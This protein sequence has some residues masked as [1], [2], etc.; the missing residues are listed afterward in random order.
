MRTRD[1]NHFETQ[2]YKQMTCAVK[3]NLQRIE[4]QSVTHALANDLPAVKMIGN[5]TSVWQSYTTVSS[6]GL[7]PFVY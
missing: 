4:T 1:K 2:S 6:T 3:K 7:N 5:A